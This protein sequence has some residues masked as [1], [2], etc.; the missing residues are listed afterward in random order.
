ML[1]HK[2]KYLMYRCITW[3][4]VKMK[5]WFNKA[6]LRVKSYTHLGISQTKLLLE[7]PREI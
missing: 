3:D 5:L 7:T 4:L 1:T 2:I 6:M